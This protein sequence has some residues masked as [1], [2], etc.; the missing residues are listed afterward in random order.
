MVNKKCARGTQELGGERYVEALNQH[1]VTYHE[2]TQ[3]GSKREL[4]Q[5]KFITQMNNNYKHTYNVN[6]IL[7]N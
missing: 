6:Y 7:T 2:N 5:S 4:A 1:I 3:R